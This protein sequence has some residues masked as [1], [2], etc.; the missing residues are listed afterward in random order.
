VR[1]TRSK[2]GSAA[3]REGDAGEILRPLVAGAARMERPTND[4]LA[5]WLF[6]LIARFGV[7]V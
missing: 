3:G 6:D 4:G 2:S 7:R 5:T 1:E